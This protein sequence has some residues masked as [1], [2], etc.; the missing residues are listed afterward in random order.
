MSI[1]NLQT[2]TMINPNTAFSSFSVND[3]EAAA[4]FYSEVLDLEIKRVFHGL[5]ELQCGATKILIYPKPDHQPAN[6]TVLNFPVTDIV[7]SVDSLIKKGVVFE[8]YPELGTDKKGISRREN[9]PAGIAW[10]RDPAGNIISII[11]E[12]SLTE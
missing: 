8:Q 7:S 2:T 4:Q 3:L 10:L 1:I 5:L 9:G 12:Q 6:F 11:Q